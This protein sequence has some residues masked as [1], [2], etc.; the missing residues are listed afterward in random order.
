MIGIPGYEIIRSDRIENRGGGVAAYFRTSLNV[1]ELRTSCIFPTH[2]NFEHVA[3]QLSTATV[4]ITFLCIYIPPISAICLDTVKNVCKLISSFLS[5]V[6]PF[7]MLGDFNF[8]TVDWNT[9]AAKKPP[10]QFFVNFCTNKCLTQLV[11][12]PTRDANILDLV[13]CNIA[14]LNHLVSSSVDPGMTTSC[15]HE[16]IS[17]TFR[18]MIL[19]QTKEYK[20]FRNFKQGDYSQI[21]SSLSRNSWSFLTTSN[22]FQQLYDSFISTLNSAI[23]NMIP[24]KTVQTTKKLRLPRHIRRLL[25]LKLKTYKLLKLGKRSKQE[26]KMVAK[27]YDVECKLWHEK[28]ESNICN[29][30]NKNKLYSF[31]NKKLRNTFSIPPLNDG[32][33]NTF[34]SD[35]EKAILFNKT[36][37]KSF[38]IDNGINVS[39]LPKK[40]NIMPEY[41][42]TAQ[43]ILNSISSTKDKL[44]Q[45]PEG[46]PPYFI[47]RV[48]KSI[49]SPLLY[50]YNFS[51][52]FNCIPTQWKQSIV[53]PIYKKGMRS[54]PSNHRPVA[55][56]SSFC[57]IKESII[58]NVMLSHL[59]YNDLLLPNQFGFLPNRS[60][61]DQ[62]L[63]CL[64]D[65]YT[66]YCSNTA[67]YVVY[68]DITK[69]FDSVSHVK[70]ITVLK[71]YGFNTQLLDWIQNFLSNR[72]QV[73]KVNSAFSPP[74]PIL[75]GVPQGSVLGPLLFIIFIND[76]ILQLQSN[77]NVTIALFADDTKF[78][79]NN[80]DDL[81]TCLN[82]FQTTIEHYQLKLAPQK[83]F[84]LPIAKKNDTTP[85]LHTFHINSSP[86]SLESST[87]DL[88]VIIHT[89]LK[90]ENHV[91]KISRQSTILSYQILKSFKTKN[92]WTLL[93][94]YKSYIR[95]LLEYNTEIWTPHLGKDKD[96]IES[97][98]IRYT[99]QICNRCNIPNISYQDRLYKL[100]LRS[101][102]DRRK[103]FDLIS[104][105]KI[106][107]RISVL[108]FDD[109][110]YFKSTK[111][112]LRDSAAKVRL[113]KHFNCNTW[114]GSFFYRAAKYWNNLDHNITSAKS[115]SIF[116]SK[117]K[118][119]SL[120]N[121]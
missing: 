32:N 83:C 90:W 100:G 16:F 97:V 11:S 65:W 99:K 45:T 78:F 80:P 20:S 36:F 3:I 74:L 28:I 116:K 18:S 66:S 106:I 33:G 102:E 118:T 52:R 86:L 91:K 79:S 73:V 54:S 63:W 75:S 88:G 23:D 50:I 58:S 24:M 51:S 41:I 105:F 64:H 120:D 103:E 89:E 110:F 12:S 25:K 98:Q 69:A 13:F 17:V 119:I 57:R 112:S 95:P 76:I 43:D 101:L 21:N 114:Y 29:N 111:Y 61:S 60:S 49:L 113:H 42:I 93:S 92:I 85:Q 115:L 82:S 6:N 53:V 14:A 96:C 10:A 40:C 37:H 107:N 55:L 27:N 81:Q 117:I 22:S 26:Y 109:Y 87:K 72:S 31:A 104:M 9:L 84:V 62:M 7:I 38:T 2:S 8:P 5:S 68:T 39:P 71:S 108:N 4:P 47:K 121:L 94:L 46:I 56:T 15:D 70:L 67:E 1:R 30:P 19:K 77:R 48:A 35:S 44:T 34:S 59:L